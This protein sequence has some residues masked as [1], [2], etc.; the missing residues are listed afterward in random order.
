MISNSLI[1]KTV[2][3][4]E[5]LDV[6]HSLAMN[7]AA[8]RQIKLT[9]PA[10]SLGKLELLAI[11]IAGITGNKSPIL[12]NKIIYV[13][14]G[15]HGVTDEN[16]SAYPKTVTPQMVSNFL[17]GGAA[18]NILARQLGIGLLIVNAGVS[19]D[20]NHH[21]MLIDLGIATRTSNI[22][23]GPAMTNALASDIVSRGIELV[24]SRHLEEHIDIIGLG[25]MGIG[26]STSASAVISASSKI[27]PIHTTGLVTGLDDAGY[28]RKIEVIRDAIKI[29]HSVLN[30]TYDDPVEKSISYLAAIGG[31]E[32]AALMGI[33]LGAAA[34]RIPIV[35][36]GLIS[37]A[38]ILLAQIAQPKLAKFIIPSHTSTE[39]GHSIALDSMKLG[40]PLF[41]LEMR[42][43]EG[44]GAALGIGLC[45]L[46]CHLLN[47][48]STFDEAD[49]DKSN[50]SM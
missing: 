29:N 35:A 41:D 17:S 50:Q 16:I 43:G 21:E 5:A 4:I 3:S 13:A 38:A 37:T 33:A 49:V 18:I 14:A 24:S 46:A 40:Q 9:K 28:Q 8:Q 12:N 26:N 6:P 30:K 27:D 20:F 31:H 34:N 36:D 11:R 45:D 32:I 10:G 23:T 47:D 44:T 39:P 48:M 19:G 42:L 1:S 22:R 7:T 15:E 25:E 2:G